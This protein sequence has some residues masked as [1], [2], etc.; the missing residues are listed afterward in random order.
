MQRKSPPC[1]TSASYRAKKEKSM[2]KLMIA[3]ALGAMTIGTTAQADIGID[4]RQINQQ[5]QID[6]GKR[7]GKLSA[8]ERQTLS[9]EQRAIKREEAR[10]RAAGGFSARDEIRINALLDR[11]QANINRLKNNRVRGPNDVP[12]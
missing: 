2:R 6:A 5:R 7:S 4:V 10:L 12:F 3:A 8:R 1:V 11:A 9:N